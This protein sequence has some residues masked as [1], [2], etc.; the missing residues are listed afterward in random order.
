M[1]RLH[2][3]NEIF[4]FEIYS[5][6]KEVIDQRTKEYIER[7]QELYQNMPDI[8]VSEYNQIRKDFV[9]GDKTALERL[10]A[11]S[12]QSII[13]AVSRIYAKYIIEDVLSFDEALSSSFEKMNKYILKFNE[14][15][16]IRA[17]YTQSL[18]NFYV[19]G[20]I[21]KSYI[22]AH[23]RYISE[24]LM[25]NEDLIYRINQEFSEEFSYKHL[26]INDL[27]QKI[28]KIITQLR[29]REY[30]ILCLRLGLRDGQT[31]T[32]EQIGE[33]LGMTRVRVGQ[34]MKNAL[35]KLRKSKSIKNLEPYATSDL[36]Q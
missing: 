2:N 14:L 3:T 7:G 30:E 24:T 1:D 22:K 17:H 36:N 11:L 20:A 13:S 4:D 9:E 8:T 12:G 26:N 19:F 34:I 33:V 29:P 16:K 23:N 18:I 35:N 21:Q 31:L 25:K 28:E 6:N 15:P 10:F 32:C 27:K 5:K